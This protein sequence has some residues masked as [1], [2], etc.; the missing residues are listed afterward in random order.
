MRLPTWR[1]RVPAPS[2]ASAEQHQTRKSSAAALRGRLDDAGLSA[3]EREAEQKQRAAF[4][5]EVFSHCSASELVRL[6]AAATSVSFEKDEYIIRQGE[7]DDAI[8][9]VRSGCCRVV[10]HIDD[11]MNADV[12]RTN[13]LASTATFCTSSSWHLGAT[14]E[15]DSTGGAPWRPPLLRQGSSIEERDSSV[16]DLLS[17]SFKR[18]PGLPPVA[19]QP[20][21]RDAALPARPASPREMPRWAQPRWALG[22][23]PEGTAVGPRT[24]GRVASGRSA[25][26]GS[27]AEGSSVEGS[28]E[29]D[30]EVVRP[31]FSRRSES[32]SA[33][34]GERTSLFEI[35]S[36]RTSL[37][38]ASLEH[39][40]YF[41][42]LASLKGSG[43]RSASVQCSEAT[44]V[45]C[46][47]RAAFNASLGTRTRLAIE[48]SMLEHA[49]E[50]QVQQS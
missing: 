42:E 10:K 35:R 45:L 11:L 47:E 7:E 30:L 1:G 33:E 37:F 49:E 29:E 17:P 44:S 5:A 31:R 22:G 39:C 13:S 25:E 4:L 38:V 23:I 16:E 14:A 50:Y 48:R 9:V 6:A 19:K 8:F 34:E 15:P 46:I 3:T 40:A 27:N 18:A 32:S 20:P 2:P 43:R 12:T 28:S 21:Q 24:S 41:G 36:Q 26:G